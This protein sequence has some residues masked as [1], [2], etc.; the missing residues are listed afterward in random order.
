[1]SATETKSTVMNNYEGMFL[2]HSGR[3]TTDPDAIIAQLLEM[4]E[5]CE[6]EVIV[7]RPWQEGKLAYEIENQRKGL[8]YIVLFKMPP[9]NNAQLTRLGQLNDNILRQLVI[10]HPQVIFDANVESLSSS[11]ESSEAKESGEEKPAEEET[12]SDD[13]DE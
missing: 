11:S 9:A 12:K 8:H 1:M 6:A 2:I 5:K 3:Y 4:L 10:K 7:H 13:K